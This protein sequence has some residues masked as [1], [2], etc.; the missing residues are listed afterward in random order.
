[1]VFWVF[2]LFAFLV[3]F[4]IVCWSFIFGLRVGFI[5]LGW[6]GL[7]VVSVGVG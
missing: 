3:Y 7:R 6:G 1:M 5:G 2:L 4:G